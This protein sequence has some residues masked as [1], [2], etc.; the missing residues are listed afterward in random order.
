MALSTVEPYREDFP[1]LAFQEEEDVHK[2]LLSSPVIVP[3]LAHWQN[4]CGALVAI[5][6]GRQQFQSQCDGLD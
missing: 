4:I 3:R 6:I 2:F 1:A 5:R